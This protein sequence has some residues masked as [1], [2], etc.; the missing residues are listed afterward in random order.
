MPDDI[1]KH[2]HSGFNGTAIIL[3]R[4]LLLLTSTINYLLLTS[5][6]KKKIAVVNVQIT[7]QQIKRLKSPPI[8]EERGQLDP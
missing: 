2:C 4:V 3:P 7:L 1:T 8:T 5:P 6:G